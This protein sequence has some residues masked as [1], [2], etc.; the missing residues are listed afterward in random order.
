MVFHVI[1]PVYIHPR[2][3]NFGNDKSDVWESSLRRWLRGTMS[4]S[5]EVSNQLLLARES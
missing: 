4:R 3:L 2:G 1:L 5:A